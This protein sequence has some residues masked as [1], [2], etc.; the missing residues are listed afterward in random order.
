MCHRKL[1]QVVEV[2]GKQRKQYVKLIIDRHV[3]IVIKFVHHNNYVMH[4]TQVA[5]SK[6][7]FFEEEQIYWAPASTTSALYSQLASKKYREIP[8]NQIKSVM[9]SVTIIFITRVSYINNIIVIIE[10]MYKL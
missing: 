7:R 5:Y 8:R 1:E 10:I 9:Y 2:M 3:I 4:D 6:L